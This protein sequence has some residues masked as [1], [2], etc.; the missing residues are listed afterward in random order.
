MNAVG[1]LS[2]GGREAEEENDVDGG[3]RSQ[4]S[5][6]RRFRNEEEEAAPP[7]LLEL[8]RFRSERNSATRSRDEDITR[9]SV[10]FAFARDDKGK[11]R[12]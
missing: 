7:P 9:L 5:Q 12:E 6:L 4:A 3:E 2:A 10:L 1:P 11:K 8:R